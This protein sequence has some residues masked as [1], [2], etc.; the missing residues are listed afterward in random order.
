[1]VTDEPDPEPPDPSD[2]VPES[3]ACRPEPQPARHPAKTARPIT[4]NNERCADLRRSKPNGRSR[5][6]TAGYR[7]PPHPEP[8]PGAS[9]CWSMA[10]VV[11]VTTTALTVLVAERSLY[12]D[13]TV[14]IAFAGAPVQENVTGR[15]LATACVSSRGKVALLPETTETLVGPFAAK[16]KSIPWPLSCTVWI[17]ALLAMVTVPERA[18]ADLGAKA[19]FSVQEPPTG[20]TAPAMQVPASDTSAKS[21]VA[22][23]AA[24]VSGGVPLLV[25][26]AAWAEHRARRTRLDL[27]LRKP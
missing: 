25:S 10:T 18:P 4:A 16:V 1:M 13:V 19:T 8:L 20:T 5:A 27:P 12:C 15:E 7:M 11:P 22:L 6:S 23:M 14:H 24:R 9:C 21:P 2:P 3:A 17:A 26:V